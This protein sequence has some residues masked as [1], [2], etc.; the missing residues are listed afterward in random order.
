[1]EN[2]MLQY[3]T[4]SNGMEVALPI[5]YFDSRW[6]AATFLTDLERAA[7]VLEGTGLQAVPQEDGKAVVL[8]MCSEYRQVDIGPYNEVAVTV[9]AVAPQDPAPAFYVTDLPV[10]TEAALRAGQELWGYNKFVTDIEIKGEGKQ[11]SAITHDPQNRVISS[12]EGTR[13]VSV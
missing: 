5:R 13:G 4:L 6:L 2:L 11:F 12:L 3:H 10:T 1:M 7:Q 8:Y 9:L